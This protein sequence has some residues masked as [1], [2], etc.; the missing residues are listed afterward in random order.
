[1]LIDS[2]LKSF[3]HLGVNLGLEPIL[4]L[5]QNL[6]NPHHSIPI[7][8]V[9]GTNGKGSVCAYLSSI[10]TEAGY[11]VGRYTSPHLIDWTERICVNNQP[12]SEIEFKAIL[13]QIKRLINNFEESPTQFEVITA[14]AWVYFAQKKVDIA[15]IEVGLGGRLDS[16]NV[17]E[18]P[19]VS[20][21]TSISREH[22]QILGP[23]IGNIAQEKAGILKKNCPAVIGEL[24]LEAEA[25]IKA[26]IEV[27]N[28]PVVWVKPALRITG[29]THKTIVNSI[30]GVMGW[31]PILPLG[32]VS[33]SQINDHWAKYKE[34]EY[35]LS[36]LGDIQLSNSAIA[37]ETITILQQKG[38][39][40]PL[41][42]IQK[43]MKKTQWLG[44]LQWRRW[45]NSHLLI[46]GAHNTASAEV[47]RQYVDS[48]DK[49]IIWVMGM[50]STK[51][52]DKIFQA[53]LRSHDSLY[54]VP[55]PD[56][57]SENTENLAKLAANICPKLDNI[58][59]FTDVFSALE[60]AVNMPDKLIVLCG[61]LYLVGY[62]LKLTS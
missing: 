60:V 54:L 30:D 17:C 9:G 43:G 41:I 22:W 52:H 1:M 24:P 7:I 62:F 27:L 15:V 51:E 21:I 3:Q 19:L 28:C 44:R 32:F 33:K 5:L 18:H 47:L 53:L 31:E 23:T 14:A 4:N 10:L 6:G 35:P 34:I 57:D 59:T 55:V 29:L 25:V 2:F 48:L 45:R 50:L 38:W 36:L 61:S 20:V 58:K 8:H 56:Y 40:I 37:L 46:D 13:T 49:E 12:I 26:K 39:N 42:A 16:T 11:Q